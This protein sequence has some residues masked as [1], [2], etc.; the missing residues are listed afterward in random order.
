MNL[1][2]IIYTPEK[3][4]PTPDPVERRMA[5]VRRKM[6]ITIIMQMMW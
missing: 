2:Y 4:I 3:T 5:L 6:E 1:F